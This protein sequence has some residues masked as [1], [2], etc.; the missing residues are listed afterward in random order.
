MDADIVGYLRATAQSCIRLVQSCPHTETAHGL[1][2]IAVDLME[3]ALEV[4]N[5]SR[6]RSK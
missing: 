5:R 3:K 2:A 6:N 4:E 1:E